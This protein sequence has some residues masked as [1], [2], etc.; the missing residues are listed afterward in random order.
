MG[1]MSG[2]ASVAMRRSVL[3]CVLATLFFALGCVAGVHRMPHRPVVWHDHDATPFAPRPPERYVSWRFDA[4]DQLVLR[5][6]SEVW[7]FA[8]SSEA[9]NVNALDEVPDSSWF[10]N[11][12]GRFP[13][14]PDIVA[15]AA[16][17]EVE[18]DAPFP[19][20]IVG[21][22]P[23]GTNPGFTIEDANGTRFLLKTDGLLQPERASAAD[24]IVA[25]LLHAAGYYVPCN[26]VVYF[27]RAALTLA[28]DATARMSHGAELPLT[29]QHVEAVLA[30]ATRTP[31]GLYRAALSRF[32]EGEPLGPWSYDELFP[33]DP[34]DVVPH[35]RRRDLRGLFV[36]FAWTGHID[37]RQ[38]NTLAVWRDVG[39]RGHLR[40]FLIDFGDC[41][42]ILHPS[43][44]LS[45]R[46]EHDHYIGP[47][48]LFLDYLTAGLIPRPWHGAELGPAG[49]VLGYFDAERFEPDEWMPGYP[50]P[51]FD[52]RTEHDAAWMARIV[53][54]FEPAH[55]RAA[56]SVGRFSDPI[57]AA[58][59]ERVLLERRRRILARYLTRLSPLAWPR[60]RGRW[61]CLD[62]LALQSGVRARSHRRYEARIAASE[63]AFEGVELAT[64]AT[65]E[66]RACVEVPAELAY[67]AIDVAVLDDPA[68]VRDGVHPARLHV[69][70]TPEGLDVVALE[71]LGS[72]GTW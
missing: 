28:P 36:L 15:R 16:C 49:R 25:A 31:E 61:I 37:A 42:G 24:A 7:T 34:N 66:G 62:D 6:L 10:E 2:L 3:V 26:R 52:A 27:D 70:A 40:H 50:N 33:G 39:E 53:A 64:R 48:T 71:R 22:K 54:R 65:P 23:D 9:L 51:A 4:V 8:A 30:A 19:W 59:L 18:P 45:R 69:Y 20:Q 56:V 47:G 29:E 60:A 43:L 12:I 35:T 63:P 5:P 72:R 11:R 32:V 58:E 1:A 41:L 21:G 46:F 14:T 38:E 17:D 44:A 13:I 55:V 57:V 68:L 67:A